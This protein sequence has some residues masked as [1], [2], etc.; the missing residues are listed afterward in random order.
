VSKEIPSLR[1]QWCGQ[2]GTCNRAIVPITNEAGGSM[3]DEERGKLRVDNFEGLWEVLEK[4]RK[5]K[6][7][8]EFVLETSMISE[9][10]ESEL[11]EAQDLLHDADTKLRDIAPKFH[12]LILEYCRK[13]L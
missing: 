3:T 2:T 5:T 11:K 8:L 13:C 12:Q 6:R 1:Y 4:V 9:E 7:I 10:S